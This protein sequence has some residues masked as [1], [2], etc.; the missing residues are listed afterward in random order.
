[1]IIAIIHKARFIRC[2]IL[3]FQEQKDLDNI[4]KLSS[5]YLYRT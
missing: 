2:K 1:M 5:S 3:Y 4:F